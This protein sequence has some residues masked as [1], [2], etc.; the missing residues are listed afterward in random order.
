MNFIFSQKLKREI[1]TIINHILLRHEGVFLSY[2][3]SFIFDVFVVSG[4]ITNEISF[5]QNLLFS[6]SISL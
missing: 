6:N 1:I 2:V 3:S 5:K 4:S